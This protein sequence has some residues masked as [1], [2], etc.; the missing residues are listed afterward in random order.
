[1]TRRAD[2]AVSL[3]QE[4]TK[5][6]STKI[7][8]SDP[9]SS[10]S[11]IRDTDLHLAWLRSSLG[12]SAEHDRS[13]DTLHLRLDHGPLR[14]IPSTTSRPTTVGQ[15]DP[16]S[17]FSSFL[18]GTPMTLHSNVTWP[19]DLF[20]TPQARS[21]YSEIQAYLLALRTTQQRVL[22]VWLAITS[23][24][25]PGRLET[26]WAD[27]QRDVWALT[28]LILFFFE[29]LLGHFMT[30]IIDVQHK[31]LLAELDPPSCG[32]PVIRR[33][34]S[35]AT[36]LRGS[37][38]LYKSQSRDLPSGQGQTPDAKTATRPDSP[39]ST[40]APETVRSRI[41]PTPNRHTAH[42]DFLTLRCV[43]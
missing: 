1:L 35:V 6:H 2:Y 29:E 16:E 3:I 14:A 18:L 36:S 8:L 13:L 7:I 22:G 19:L 12:T 32:D 38:R 24:R 41:P 37:T 26:P 40:Y 5:L 34:G 10:S 11:V 39:A 42:L 33:S 17:L 30:D 25:R 20:I 28:K 23:S 27:L 43:G 4:L 21:T 15:A 9:S 31:T